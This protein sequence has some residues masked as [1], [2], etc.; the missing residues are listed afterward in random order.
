MLFLAT[1]HS[2]KP[3]FSRTDI[4]T[5][6]RSINASYFLFNGL[7]IDSFCKAWSTSSMI[8]NNWSQWKNMY[9]CFICE[10]TPLSPKH[11]Y[12]TSFGYPSIKK[13]ISDYLANSLGYLQ[14]APRSRRGCAFDCVRLKTWSWCPLLKRCLHMWA[15]MTPVPIHPILIGLSIWKINLIFL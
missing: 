6:D 4:P 2:Y 3:S 1:T 7:F 12:S 13:R 8:Y 15:P 9:P 5:W 14:V 11:I 10:R